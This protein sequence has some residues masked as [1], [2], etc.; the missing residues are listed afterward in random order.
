ML[1]HHQNHHPQPI[2]RSRVVRRE[3]V[4]EKTG[5]TSHWDEIL[6]QADDYVPGL[7]PWDVDANVRALSELCLVLMNSN[8]FLY[9][10]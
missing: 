5:G 3:F 9:V 10:E 8:E 4:D 6:D 2:Q 1:A 7:Q